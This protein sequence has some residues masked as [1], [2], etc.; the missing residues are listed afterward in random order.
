MRSERA[1]RFWEK[2]RLA[3]PSVAATAAY[4][5][6]YFGNTREMALELAGL[7]LAGRK[8]ATASMLKMNELRPE[9]APLP[10]GYSVV[11]D[12][13]GEPLCV[14]QTTEIH[15][16]PFKEVDAVFAADE[17]EGDLSLEYWRRVHRDYFSKE[18]EQYGFVFDEHSTICCERFRLL[19]PR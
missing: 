5:V 3:E 14:I 1:E 2:F 9:N 19:F 6:W 18:A 10:S 7:V 15:N 8:T 16:L 13:D 17:G 11:T 4:Q 12:F